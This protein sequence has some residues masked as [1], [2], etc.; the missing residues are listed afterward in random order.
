MKEDE[1]GFEDEA[2]IFFF[3]SRFFVFFI[4][5]VGM[6]IKFKLVFFVVVDLV[7]INYVLCI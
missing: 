1:V 7:Y 6:K 3:I 5:F 2:F 4:L